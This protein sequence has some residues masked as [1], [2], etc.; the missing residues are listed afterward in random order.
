M[1]AN[2]RY[3]PSPAESAGLSN[4][5]GTVYIDPP[6]A[7]LLETLAGQVPENG[8]V[9]EIGSYHGASTIRLGRGAQKR[10]AV[11]YA[12]DPHVHVEHD[13]ADNKL[14]TFTRQD[15]ALFMGNILNNELGATVMSV[16][17]PS[18]A[19]VKAF[20]AMPDFE[21][22]LLFIDGAHDFKSVALDF[23]EYSNLLS[24]DG[25]IALH[26]SMWP[27]VKQ[28]IEAALAMEW[29]CVERVCSIS[30]L[31]RKQGEQHVTV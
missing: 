29:E 30:V 18:Q 11:V 13:P 12:V 28:V 4:F 8:A 25:R 24:A 2:K 16:A 17:L 19:A 10:N 23:V 22:D 27:G 6:E 31:R 21:I 1:R 9:V 5:N 14:V 15:N 26:D 7:D 20:K 3:V